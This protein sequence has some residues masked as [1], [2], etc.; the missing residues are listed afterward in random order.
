M[1][2]L[3]GEILGNCEPGLWGLGFRSFDLQDIHYESSCMT[4]DPYGKSCCICG[5][6]ENL[7]NGFWHCNLRENVMAKYLNGTGCPSE[8]VC[9]TAPVCPSTPPRACSPCAAP[10]PIVCCPK[11]D[12]AWRWQTTNSEYGKFYV[13]IHREVNE[14]CQSSSTSM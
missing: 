6:M 3:G 12:Q 10:R 14:P 5:H 9:P 13:S 1:K 4:S 11:K 7:L 8:P 2:S